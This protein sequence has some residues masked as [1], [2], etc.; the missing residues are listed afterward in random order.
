[1]VALRES[2]LY[3]FESLGRHLE[4]MRQRLDA[5]L[6]TAQ[7]GSRRNEHY[8]IILWG[9]R[10][11]KFLFDDLVFSTVS[12]FDYTGSMIGFVVHAE[13]R[14]IKWGGIRQCA[15]HRIGNDKT[16]MVPEH[17]RIFDSVIGQMAL[18]INSTWLKALSDYRNALIH[19]RS[20]TAGGEII[21]RWEAETDSSTVH[22]YVTAPDEFTRCFPQFAHHNREDPLDIFAAAEWL[23]LQTFN[24]SVRLARALVDHMGGNSVPRHV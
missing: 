7:S 3:R 20:D 16:P 1:M 19:E 11:L 18:E 10:D 5:W 23:I 24:D 12:L 22:I 9:S 2:V 15:S 6:R 13:K 8:E 4:I 17:N 21:E 14:N